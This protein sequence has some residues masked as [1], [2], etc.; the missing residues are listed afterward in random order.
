M[1]HLKFLET[2]TDLGTALPGTY[3]LFLVTLSVVIACLAA[4]AALGLSGRIQA[5]ERTNEKRIWLAAGAMAMGIGVWAMH[6][7]GMLAFKL[8][9][10]IA[11]DV[12]ITMLSMVPAVVAGGITLY[13]IS[14]A[15]VGR[16]QVFVGGVLMG[17]GVGTMH[18]IGMAAMRTAAV[19]RYHF[20]LFVLSIAVAIVLATVALY[21]NWRATNG[22]TQDR[23][24]GTKFGAALVLGVSVAAMHYTGMAAAYFFP[25]SMP[26]DGGFMLEPVLLSVL[27]SVAVILIL[28]L[29]IFVVVVDRRLKAAAHSVRL[30]R[31]RMLEAIESTAEAFSL[32]DSDDKLVLCNSKYRE[33]FNLDKI[34]I[35][36][37]MT[38]ENI[39]Q[40]AAELGLVS[41][42]EGRINVW[43]TERLARH[44]NPT[45]PYIEQQPDGRWLQINEHKTDDYA[46]VAVCTDITPIKKA[47]LELKEAYETLNHKNAELSQALQELKSTQNQLIESAKMASLG[48]LTAGIAHEINNPIGALSSTTDTLIR[49]IAKLKQILE[50]RTTL[51]DVR[52]V[53]DIRKL[54]GVMENISSVVFSSN[55]RIRT[56]VNS[57]KNFV[58]L[59]EAE[60]KESN[61][62]DGIDSALTLLQYDI[63]SRISVRK[64]YGIIPQ[65]NCHPAELNQVFMTL[66]RNAIEAIEKEGAI[67][68]NTSVSN[69]N[70]SV[71]IT[72]SGKGI[73][74]E[75]IES[76]FDF[77]FTAKG[78]R[79]GMRTG[80]FNVYN[81]IQK[82]QGNISVESEVGK[83]T[84]VAICLPI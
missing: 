20:G 77:G 46:T 68:I 47:E 17:S 67:S 2:G 74:E 25:G 10:A 33:F 7:V 1:H 16:K 41:E 40:S 50:D 80:L 18:Y 21:I 44:R 65:I 30:T 76:L 43:V 6:F 39:I 14:R 59:D 48:R 66:L 42:A 71:E 34:G 5:A 82:H 78:S 52:E 73:P 60:F 69:N 55:D 84:T 22:I 61:L 72:D 37:G 81:T 3:N 27:I 11:Y 54:L 35:R 24:Y 51:P 38:F 9:V 75:K 29:A 62:H 83:G 53:Q 32:Y 26:G 36:P 8:P 56:V 63:G 79:V 19:M 64:N 31:T 57:L 70:L 23:N 58:R 12:G 49:C 4:Y 15:S 45:Q 28:A 13:V